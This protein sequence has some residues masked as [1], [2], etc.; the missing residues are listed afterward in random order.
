MKNKLTLLFLIFFFSSSLFSQNLI[1]NGGFEIGGSGV[2]FVTNGAGYTPLN[3]PYSGTTTTGNFAIA[4]NP[5]SINTTDFIPSSD[6]TSG[7]GKMLIIDGNTNTTSPRFW[8]AG[9][10]GAGITTLTI[11]T[12]Y[13][14]SYWIESVSNLGSQANINVLIK[15]ASALTLVTANTVAPLP[16]LAWRQVIYSFVATTT[17]ATIELWNSNTSAVGNDFA[18]D[19][20]MLT[21]DL[22][23]TYNVTDAMCVTANDG[24][25]TVNGIGGTLP[26]VNYT[27]TGPVSTNNPTGV[28]PGLPPG[29]YTVSVTDSTLPVAVTATI[30]NVVVG[31]S[32]TVNGNPGVCIGSSTSLSV[33][34]SPNGYSWTSNP[35]GFTSMMPNPTVTPAVPT[36]YTVT[37][38]IGACSVSKSFTV[39]VNPLPTATISIPPANATIC[40]GNTAVITIT[41]TPNSRVTIT[42]NLGNTYSAAIG[43]AGT[44]IF[45]T[46]VLNVSTVYTLVNVKNNSTF[47]QRDYTGVTVTITVVPNGN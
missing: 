1:V 9:N 26:Y 18:V 25:I 6:H 10:T 11:G 20:F 30:G 2:G 15:D 37:S 3:T 13:R 46:P 33:T 17:T 42:N 45:T 31:P 24:S 7:I 47:C 27:L 38:T 23:V 34:G 16:V 35:A 29:I 22:M 43:A 28:F 32:L 5:N 4:T 39:T 8:K 14:F 12:T 41:G 36:V 44:G 40:P 19:D 21:D